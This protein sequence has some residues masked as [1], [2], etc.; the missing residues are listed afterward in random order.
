MPQIAAEATAHRLLPLDPAAPIALELMRALNAELAAISGDSGAARFDPESVRQERALFM[1]ALGAQGEG[2][3]CAALRPLGE[4]H[5]GVAELK[6]MY[7][8]AGTRGVGSALLRHLELQAVDL[9]Y[10]ELWL[11]TRPANARALAFYRRHGYQE[12][13]KYGDYAL[14]PDS[15]CLGKTLA[16][17]LRLS[18]V[19][20]SDEALHAQLCELLIDSVQ[21]D[22]SVGFLKPLGMAEAAGYWQGVAR[23]LGPAQRLLL[24]HEGQQLLGS[25]QLALCQKPN[26]RHRAELQKLFVHSRAR[27]R[28]LATLLLQRVDEIA[29]A[30][31]CS[32]LVLDT[33][34]GSKAEQVY[35]HLGW[36]H[37][38]NIPDYATTPEGKLHPTALY[39]KQL[40]A[41]SP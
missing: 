27:G 16:Q 3:G 38:G 20:G 9:G 29:R 33:E 32:L 14:R 23:S 28:G 22:A 10:R 18:E 40:R 15:I 39:F 26:G 25:V 6:R 5:A 37:A 35:R 7:A 13:A 41:T 36:Q 17:P 2:L 21:H 1:V 11:E 19:S 24:L 34:S 30:A 31:G 4:S 8:Q 12:I